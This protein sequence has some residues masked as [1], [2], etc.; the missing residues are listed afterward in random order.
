MAPLDCRTGPYIRL[1]VNDLERSKAFYTEL[2]GF[3]VAMDTLPPEA[4][5]LRAAGRGS[6]GRIVLANGD[7]LMGLRPTRH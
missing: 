2:L 4:I 3:Q 7:L 5:Q 1:T 6:P